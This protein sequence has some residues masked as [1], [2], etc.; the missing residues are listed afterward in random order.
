MDN[1]NFETSSRD[2][3]QLNLL[4]NFT[5]RLRDSSNVQFKNFI[6][7][8]GQSSTTTR[9]SRPYYFSNGRAIEAVDKDNILS[10]FS[11]FL[12]A[13]NLGGQHYYQHA[14]KSSYGI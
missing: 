14:N 3:A 1:V 10:Y 5:Y 7:N 4:Q 13:G 8:Q 12:Y 2:N 9:I 6:L 11:R